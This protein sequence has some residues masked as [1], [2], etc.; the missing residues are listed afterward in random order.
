MEWALNSLS[1]ALAQVKPV[2]R[3]TRDGLN[4]LFLFSFAGFAEL[5][6][7]RLV[8]DCVDGLCD[9]D[10]AGEN[11]APAVAVEAVGGGDGDNT[12]QDA[13]PREVSPT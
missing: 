6:A 10:D 9:A 5:A 13:Q 7:E 1:G 8:H 11:D 3:T 2:S 4:F 12:K